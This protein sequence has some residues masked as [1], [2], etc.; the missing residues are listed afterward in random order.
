MTLLAN[1][2]AYYEEISKTF[3]LFG[4]PAMQL[5][6][7]L[8]RRPAGL[9][10]S[11]TED[12]HVA[13]SWDAAE[14]AD[15]NPVTGYNIYRKTGATGSYVVINA[16]LIDDTGF[17]DENVTL[18]TRYYYVVRSVDGDGTESVDSESVSMV[19]SAPAAS[20]AGSS[21]GS[22]SEPVVFCFISTAAGTSGIDFIKALSMIGAMALIWWLLATRRPSSPNG[23]AAASRERP[24]AI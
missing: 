9:A 22:D 16:A 6:V 8:P 3:L 2:D 17:V 7:P 4:D 13:L 20:L 1:G 19:P 21:S 11:Q 12:Y 14:D 15:G 24:S 23:C 10:A 5:K 18:G